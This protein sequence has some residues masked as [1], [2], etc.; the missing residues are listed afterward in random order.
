VRPVDTAGAR[1]LIERAVAGPRQRVSAFLEQLQPRERRLVVWA[2]VAT[3]ALLVWFAVIDPIADSVASLDRDLT[4]TR[5]DAAQIGD[6][7]A[8]YKGLQSDVAALERAN[9]SHAGESAF[10]QLESIAVP[11]VGREHITAMNPSTRAVGE[12]LQEESVEM[13]VEGVPMRG[14]I[15]LLYSIENR[16][17]PMQAVRVAFKRQYKNPELVDATLV[18]A[19]VRPQ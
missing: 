14:L 9:A 11:I 2:T 10:A 1:R 18:V 16:D 7:V 8:R 12:K 15:S 5:R 6:L 19:R 4:R 17:R 13:H 3:A